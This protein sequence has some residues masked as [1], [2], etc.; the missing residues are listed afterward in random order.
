M[1]LALVLGYFSDPQRGL[2][3]DCEGIPA[4]FW[5]GSGVGLMAV[6][7]MM[8]D[9]LVRIPNNFVLS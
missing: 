2:F 6:Q 8:A 7:D 1:A 3:P 9:G 4:L 5:H